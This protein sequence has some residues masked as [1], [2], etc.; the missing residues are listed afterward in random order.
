MFGKCK[1]LKVIVQKLKSIILIFTLMNQITFL[2][3]I[4]WIFA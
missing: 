4:G 2:D 3:E 1:K